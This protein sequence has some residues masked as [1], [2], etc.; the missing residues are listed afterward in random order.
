MPH[1]V[2]EIDDGEIEIIPFVIKF[3]AINVPLVSNFNNIY[4]NTKQ[5]WN[6]SV[7]FISSSLGYI[8]SIGIF[9]YY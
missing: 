2:R 8:K 3:I 4:P 6:C 9:V 7:V 1:M 5:I